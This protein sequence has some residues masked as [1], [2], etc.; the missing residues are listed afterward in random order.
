MPVY[1]AT[2]DSD[3]P[4]GL[5]IT[6]DG[7]RK[8]PPLDGDADTADFGPQPRPPEARLVSL[9]DGHRGV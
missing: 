1:L 7:H 6:E 2:L 4:T 5:F 9:P 3:G 8:A